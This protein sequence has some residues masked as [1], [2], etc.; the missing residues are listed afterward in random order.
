M[1]LS[2]SVFMLSLSYSYKDNTV[3]VTSSSLELCATATSG[4]QKS[5]FLS[6]C[7]M[8]ALQCI[9]KQYTITEDSNCKWPERNTAGCAKCHIWETCVGRDVQV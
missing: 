5:A 2:D 4:T 6:V 3:F 7:K 9:G 1:E 8:H